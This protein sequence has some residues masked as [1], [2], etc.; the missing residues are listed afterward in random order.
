MSCLLPSARPT[1]LATPLLVSLLTLA[2]AHGC[3][4]GA[5]SA[6]APRSE[7]ASRRSQPHSPSALTDVPVTPSG[8]V[9]ATPGG[10]QSER[11]RASRPVPAAASESAAMV[12]GK[13][14]AESAS[15][16]DAAVA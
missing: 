16:P 10:R 11:S 8:K 9:N 5:G 12:P 14:S 13:V 4:P 1:H 2:L 15:A 3:A 6:S 7:L